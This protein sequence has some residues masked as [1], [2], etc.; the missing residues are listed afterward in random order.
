MKKRIFPESKRRKRG[1]Y[2][3]KAQSRSGKELPP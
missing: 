1:Y 3:I 2:S